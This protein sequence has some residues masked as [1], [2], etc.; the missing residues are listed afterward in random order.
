VTPT[1]SSSAAAK[2]CSDSSIAVT[3]STD[4]KSY[5]SNVQPQLFMSVRN[6]GT[7]PCTRDVGQA[8]LEL[9]VL[10]KAG[11]QV[12]SSDDCSPGGKHDIVTLAPNQVFRTAVV[13][14]R[15]TTKQGCP[16]GQ[17]AAASGSY[18]LKGRDGTAVSAPAA[19][20]LI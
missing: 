3:V 13:W 9:R 11:V 10:T 19:F 5:P 20:D 6:S 15:V 4:A 12:W 17:P 18:Q 2:P 14:S 16:S 8:A 7:A 1:V